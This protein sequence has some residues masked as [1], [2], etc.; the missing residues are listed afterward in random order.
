MELRRAGSSGLQLSRL[1]LGTMTWG[2]DTDEHEA[3]DQCRAFL[4]AGGNFIDTAAVYGD[5]DSERVIGGLVG[6]LFNRDEV[7]I[8]T[9]AGVTFPEGV[10]TVD[11]SRSH[12]I[13]QLEKSLTRLGTDF[14]DL[15]QIHAWDPNN[16]LDDTLSALDYAYSSGKARYVGVCNFSGWQSARAITQQESIQSKAP[17]TTLQNEYSLLNRNVENELIDCVSAL[18]IGLL[19]WSPLGRGVLTGKYRRGIPSDSRGAT[20]HFASFVDP[21][22]DDR[23]SRI[24]EAVAVAAER[25]GFSPLEVAL[26]WVRDAPGVTSAIVGARTGAQLRGILLSEQMTLPLIVRDVLDEVSS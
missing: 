15:W 12:L 3:A 19:A 5:G 4:D 18:N 6:T 21:Y 8:A 24:V 20:P 17:V 13:S 11:N 7:V 25:L 26:A 16:P 10:R 23:S 22:L 2:R 9:K 1:G 14:V